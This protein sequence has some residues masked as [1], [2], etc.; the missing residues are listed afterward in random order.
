MARLVKLLGWGTVLWTIGLAIAAAV[1]G[2]TAD[3]AD[4][5]TADFHVC[6][7][8]RDSTISGLAFIWFLGVLPVAILWLLSRG[9]RRRCRICADELGA[10][11]RRVCRRCATRLVETAEPR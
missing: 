3:C 4:V 7:L 8:D 11:D 2:I 10:T 6:E 9:R 1:V 5:A